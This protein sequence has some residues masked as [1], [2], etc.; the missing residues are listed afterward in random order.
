M[1][2]SFALSIGCCLVPLAWVASTDARA[3]GRRPAA[4]RDPLCALPPLDPD[5]VMGI[6]LFRFDERGLIIL[7]IDMGGARTAYA[8]DRDG[9]L[10]RTDFPDG[11][12][13]LFEFG[14]GPFANR[15]VAKRDRR[16]VLHVYT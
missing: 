1:V 15:L 7:R 10:V 6:P 3:A 5:L 14:E 12:T 4:V 8:Y 13:E 11:T 16:G 2:R 9:R